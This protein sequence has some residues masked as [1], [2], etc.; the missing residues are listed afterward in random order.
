MAIKTHYGAAMYV[1]ATHRD[2]RAISMGEK[3][4]EV[5]NLIFCMEDA[6]ADHHLPHAYENLAAALLRLQRQAGVSRFIRPRDPESLAKIL[7]MPGIERIDGFVLPKFT[8]ANAEFFLDSLAGTDFVIMPTLETLEVFEEHSMRSLCRDL[9]IVASKGSP[10]I[11]AMRIGGNDLLSLI[12]MRRPRGITIYDTPIGDVISSLV[13]V[14]KPQ[15]FQLTAPVFEHFEDE[16]TLAQELRR[17]LAHGLCGKTA[18]HPCQ[19]DIIER[20]YRVS[21]EDIALARQMLD[22]ANPAVFKKHGTMCEPATHRHW[23]MEVLA[24]AGTADS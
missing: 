13:R 21:D 1:P 11:A 20:F 9:S 14:F 24:R 18:I 4:T 15:G 19:V 8:G 10:A 3:L 16:H 2:L 17:D 12:G 23:A 5:R 22:E 6:V 7:S